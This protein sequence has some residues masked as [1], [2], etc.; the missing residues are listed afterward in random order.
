M[1]TQAENHLILIDAA[2]AM[3]ERHRQL[4]AASRESIAVEYEDLNDSPRAGE[5][6]MT[7]EQADVLA[8]ALKNA[9]MSK[10]QET[11]PAVA[12]PFTAAQRERMFRNRPS[13]VGK[14][15][16]LAD[17]HRVVQYVEAC[18]GIKTKEQS[19]D[20]QQTVSAASTS[21]S[22]YR[23][24]CNR[25]G[26]EEGETVSTYTVILL[27]P[28]YIA[29]NYGEDYYFWKG[30]AESPTDAARKAQQFLASE[31]NNEPEDFYVVVVIGGEPKLY[32][33]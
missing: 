20:C 8:E 3:H 32:F 1:T 13:D 7:V 22:R 24:G 9:R 11:P 12:E 6:Y 14:G 19:N 30:E 28:D 23:T 4:L 33:P 21:D 15:L 27:Y 26:N 17:W 2:R 5:I 25:R 29:S 18:H 16:S 31:H 10:A